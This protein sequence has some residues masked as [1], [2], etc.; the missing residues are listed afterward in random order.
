MQKS[1]GLVTWRQVFNK[2]CIFN[3]SEIFTILLW[4]IN[5][6]NSAKKSKQW[7]LRQNFQNIT[8]LLCIGH[9]NFWRYI[10]FWCIYLRTKHRDRKDKWFSIRYCLSEQNVFIYDKT[11]NKN[12]FPSDI[13]RT[14][15]IEISRQRICEI[16]TSMCLHNTVR[17][18]VYI[19][20]HSIK[21]LHLLSLTVLQT[22]TNYMQT[23]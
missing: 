14:V 3:F 6:S 8:K 13:E 21:I 11:P 20:R 22:K 4:N 19:I 17:I 9:T 16:C 5:N 2:F 23:V 10:S 7:T 15:E 18:G 1:T 12:V